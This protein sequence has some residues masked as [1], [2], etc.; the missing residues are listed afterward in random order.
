MLT[1]KI[2]KAIYVLGIVI[3]LY[4]ILCLVVRV[5]SAPAATSSGCHGL[6]TMHHAQYYGEASHS[7]RT[8]CPFTRRVIRNSL[9]FIVNHGGEGDGDFFIFA[10]SPVTGRNYRM[11]C[12]ANG[13][14]YKE[15]GMHVD[16]RGGFGARVVYTAW[17]Y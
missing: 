9:R 6:F 12:F 17:G 14:L 10:Y 13:S 2:G 5:V 8:S 4:V 16:C 7:T 3:F 15:Y 1:S 11:H